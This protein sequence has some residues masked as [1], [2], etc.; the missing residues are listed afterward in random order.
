MAHILAD[1]LTLAGVR[2][3]APVRDEKYTLDL[4][5]AANPLANYVLLAVGVAAVALAAALGSAVG[6]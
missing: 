3:F 2:P 4:A 6:G 5:K 1:V